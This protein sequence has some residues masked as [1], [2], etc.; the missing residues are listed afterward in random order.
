MADRIIIKDS[1]VAST[2]DSAASDNI[3]FIIGTSFGGRVEQNVPTLCTS[4]SEFAEAFGNN[5]DTK[6]VTETD[7]VLSENVV[8]L[9]EVPVDGTLMATIH[10]GTGI[11]EEV[12]LKDN[13]SGYAI[14][15]KEDGGTIVAVI[16]KEQKTLT[17]DPEDNVVSVEKIE[18]DVSLSLEPIDLIG[19]QY[20]ITCLSNGFPV[21]YDSIKDCVNSVAKVTPVMF[22]QELKEQINLLGEDRINYDFKFVPTIY[23]IVTNIDDNT[24]DTTAVKYIQTI[25]AKCTE[26]GDRVVLLDINAKTPK[27]MRKVMEEKIPNANGY[28]L[29]IGNRG[30]Y[31]TLEMPGSYWYL[32][33]LSDSVTNERKPVYEAIANTDGYVNMT[34][35][36]HTI[37]YTYNDMMTV[38]QFEEGYG[39]IPL[40]KLNRNGGYTLFGNITCL[41]DTKRVNPY[42]F[43]SVRLLSIE[44][45]RLLRRIG[46]VNLFASDPK[47]V[48]RQFDII[49]RGV[50]S[51]MVNNGY[52]DTYNISLSV[53]GTKVVGYISMVA[54]GT[55]EK[56][57]IGVTT[58]LSSDVVVTE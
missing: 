19:Y 8:Q 56:I 23:D 45:K 12:V 9:T 4:I 38:G 34:E 41:R 54:N 21:L 57:D 28:C 31:G 27:L 50:L 24:V 39:I 3:V 10:V 1:V 2:V 14:G 32:S 16:N 46:M 35:T 13:N 18:Y 29:C 26:L 47:Q 42:N 7:C 20:A 44:V 52:L 53:Q 58:E 51:K 22:L 43:A 36:E 30:G 11:Q 5:T 15:I 37:K 6:P 17:F 48:V 33:R 49:V 40:G 25:I 55:V